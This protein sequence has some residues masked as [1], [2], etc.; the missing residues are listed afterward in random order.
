MSSGLRSPCRRVT[1][2]GRVRALPACWAAVQRVVGQ[3][4]ACALLV[5]P[6]PGPIAATVPGAWGLTARCAACCCSCARCLQRPLAVWTRQPQRPR[7]SGT[8]THT[9]WRLS[10]ALLLLLA[11]CADG[12]GEGAEAGPQEQPQSDVLVCCVHVRRF[13][14]IDHTCTQH[15]GLWAQQQSSCN[16][17]AAPDLVVLVAHDCC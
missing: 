13:V 15:T 4:A 16:G 11:V 6:W 8:T 1:D 3:R 17:V 12:R 14:R 2:D 7:R 10:G 5:R 9:A